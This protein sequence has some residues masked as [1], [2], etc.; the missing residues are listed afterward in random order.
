M[1]RPARKAIP[2]RIKLEVFARQQGR[3]AVTGRRLAS[4][5]HAQF[6]HHPAIELR[7]VAPSGDDFEPAQL[8][9]AYIQALHPDAHRAKTSDDLGRIAKAKRIA[10]K[11][12]GAEKPPKSRWPKRPFPKR[13]T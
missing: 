1:S 13:K 3:C 7:P 8:D 9:P 2:D 4:I 6:D 10:A 12:A 11:H 5:W